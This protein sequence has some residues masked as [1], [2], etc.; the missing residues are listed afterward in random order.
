M[1]QPGY[2]FMTLLSTPW[3]LLSLATTIW[4]RLTLKAYG[5]QSTPVYMI[6][7]E[8]PYSTYV[9]SYVLLQLLH[10][11][12]YDPDLLWWSMI[13]HRTRTYLITTTLLLTQANESMIKCG[14]RFDG[15]IT[16][17]SVFAVCDSVVVRKTLAINCFLP[18]WSSSAHSLRSCLRWSLTGIQRKWT[19]LRVDKHI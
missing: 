7:L 17:P 6:L 12:I 10:S 9:Y 4:N 1:G 8:L 5:L 19:Q 11:D 16:W 15:A 14:D 2:H 3:T 18:I 13:V